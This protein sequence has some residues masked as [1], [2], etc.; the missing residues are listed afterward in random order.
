MAPRPETKRQV[1]G[2]ALRGSSTLRQRHAREAA[3]A[4]REALVEALVKEEVVVEE[5]GERI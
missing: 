5:E 4:V 3:A 1:G 2:G